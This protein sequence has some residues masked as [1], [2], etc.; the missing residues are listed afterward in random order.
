TTAHKQFSDWNRT[1]VDEKKS[2]RKIYAPWAVKQERLLENLKSVATKFLHEIYALFT[3][4]DFRVEHLILRLEKAYD[5]F[6]P[7]LDELAYDTLFVLA[8][9]KTK[10]GFVLF[11]EQ[12]MT[13]ENDHIRMILKLMKT[14][15]MMLL[16]K[17]N[18]TFTKQNLECN[19]ISDYRHNHLENI[20]SILKSEELEIDIDEK[21]TTKK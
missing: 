18:T 17:D 3:A 20:K 15:K 14:N 19:E 2:T 12:L 10:K 8:Q 16:F 1:W 4:E 6:Y 21:K 9:S 5:Y 13:F 11:T 7:K